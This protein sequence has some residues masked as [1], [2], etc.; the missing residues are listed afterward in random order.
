MQNEY[1]F[2]KIYILNQLCS[3]P[4]LLKQLIYL[5]K[6]KSELYIKTV[7]HAEWDW[8]GGCK[9]KHHRNAWSLTV[10]EFQKSNQLKEIAQKENS[11]TNFMC[12]DNAYPK[13]SSYI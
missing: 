10:L 13:H 1:V 4:E 8:K 11:P 5:L 6:K 7:F 12:W 2:I 3:L 9:R